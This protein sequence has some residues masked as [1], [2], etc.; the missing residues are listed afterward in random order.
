[1]GN[2][3]K[4]NFGNGWEGVI[5]NLGDIQVKKGDPVTMGMKL[6]T[7]G[8]SSL[9]QKPWLYLELSKDGKA[10]NPLLYLIQNK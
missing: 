3:I 8:I 4:I 2:V 9:R 1:L 5:G 10:V 6:G 7:V